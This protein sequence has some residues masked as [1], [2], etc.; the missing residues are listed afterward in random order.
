MSVPLP[1]LIV[2][3]LHD[4][5]L[6]VLRPH[7]DGQVAG[8]AAKIPALVV[9]Q[10]DC[11]EDVALAVNIPHPVVLLQLAQLVVQRQEGPVEAGGDLQ[12]LQDVAH[13]G[14]SRHGDSFMVNPTLKYFS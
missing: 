13:L 8:V 4:D 6:S 3:G 2:T 14:I 7:Q 11:C 10:L 9:S 5:G 12:L 1:D